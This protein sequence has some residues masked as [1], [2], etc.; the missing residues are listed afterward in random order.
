MKFSTKEDIEAPID[1]AFKL[2]SDFDQFERSALRR[3]AEVNRTDTLRKKGAGMAWH[4]VFHLR[5]KERK[6]DAKMSEY[7]EPDNYCL[8]ML[9]EDITAFATVDLM[10]LSKNRTRAS[11]ALELKPKSLSG[12]LMIQTLR[13]GKGRLQRRFKNKTADFVRILERDY[14]ADRTG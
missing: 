3:G 8:E 11:I 12:R 5:G 4:A 1:D 6:I 2:F 9:S 7:N 10:P 14:K 13:L